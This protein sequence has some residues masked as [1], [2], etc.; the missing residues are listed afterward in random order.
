MTSSQ[1][2]LTYALFLVTV[3]LSAFLLFQVQP[4]ISKY[5][6]P[7]FG[8][9]PAV[10][11]TCM[12][13]FQIALFGGYLYAHLLVQNLSPRM[14]VFVHAAVLGVALLL[15][16]ITP[17]VRWK[18][19]DGSD[20]TLSIIEL[21]AATVG[22]PYFA[23]STTGPLLQGWFARTLPGRSPYRLY[24]LSNI[25]SL[26]ALLSYPFLF[27]PLLAVEQQAFFWACGF[28]A[29][30][31]L[32]GACAW[33]GVTATP[34]VLAKVAET[35]AAAAAAAAD[36]DE[37]EPEP[38]P[39]GLTVL[40]WI[41]LAAVPSVLLLAITNQ[42]C[43]DI[44]VVPFL[45][46]V[47]LA[48]YLLSFILC[49]DGEHWYSRRWFGTGLFLTAGGSCLLMWDSTMHWLLVVSIVGQAAIYFGLLFCACMVCHGELVTLKPSP[50]YLTKFYLCISAGG[51]LGG[52]SVGI[53]APLVFRSLFELPI[54]I[55][56]ACVLLI[57]VMRRDVK[58]V[59]F[60][61][62]PQRRTVLAGVFVVA[63]C[64]LFW[65]QSETANRGVIASARNFY[66]VLLVR[67]TWMNGAPSAYVLNHGQIRHGHQFMD[68]QKRKLATTY[69]GPQSGCGLALFQHHPGKPKRVGVVGLGAGTLA[70]YAEP[71]D[72]YRM[73][74][75]NPAVVT[76][77]QEFFTYLSQCR[78]AQFEI[79]VGDG[80]IA[81]EQEEPQR[82]DVLAVDAFS[83]DAIPAHLLTRECGELYL[84][85]LAE[86][87]ILAIHITNRHVDL[88]PV[89]RGLADEFQLTARCIRNKPELESGTN[90]AK[91]V[92][93][94]R[95]PE[96][97]DALQVTQSK[98]I[99]M[100]DRTILWT[101]AFSNLLS[102]MR[103]FH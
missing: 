39:Q 27:E 33:R 58:S 30:T 62:K 84:K 17:D 92:L 61:E 53:V 40:L 75:I 51:A 66:G 68:P 102:V 46:V 69:Y 52:V 7:W 19:T 22:L 89:C 96:V 35:A 65:K 43:T 42:V 15:L 8:G 100:G 80:R 47:P 34:V 1:Q 67:Q 41:A 73:Y 18:P 4:L 60:R 26:L 79:V 31:L 48:L 21:L 6:L 86:D 85:H 56:S 3:F 20:P 70:V 13:F 81:L 78:A 71:H 95:R 87:G 98:V 88:L 72:Y 76:L 32:C 83:G 11:T 9:T 23:L 97:L 5:I 55:V 101:D 63:L 54:A 57:A 38:E 36:D 37:P 64:V 93:L 99:P 49:F 16:P 82:F 12:L 91:W 25:G 103:D 94:S 45:W 24:A 10:W 44:A 14:Q 59:L 50:K 77:A 28:L 2:R 29:F 90:S 74:E